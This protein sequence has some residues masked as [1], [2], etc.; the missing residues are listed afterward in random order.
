MKKL[1]ALTSAVLFSLIPLTTQADNPTVRLDTDLGGITIELFPEEAP[2]SVENF[3]GYVR[4]GFYDGTLFHRVIPGFMMQ[5]G[6]YTFDFAKKTAKDTIKNE[7]DNGLK[8]LEGT[9]AMART[10]NPDSASSQFF[11]NLE[12]NNHL[13]YQEGALGYTVFGKVIDGMDVVDDILKEPRGMYR[14]F[15]DSPNAIVRILK[16]VELK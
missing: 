10:S 1:F 14:S 16:A 3:L 6:G 9:L 4:S 8:N 11:I 2:I 5:A 15:P 12:D 7:S 13:D